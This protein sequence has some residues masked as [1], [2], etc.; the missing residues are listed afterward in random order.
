MWSSG[1]DGDMRE[2][3]AN[4]LLGAL[5]DF[6]KTSRGLDQ[7][8]SDYVDMYEKKL[9]WLQKC[10]GAVVS[11]NYSL[12]LIKNANI[13][14]K[15]MDEIFSKVDIW[16]NDE[17]VYEKTKAALLNLDNDVHNEKFIQQLP[18]EM[19]KL[20]F[21][22][23]SDGDLSS[24]ART[25][26]PMR[27]LCYETWSQVSLPLKDLKPKRKKESF[28]AFM[29]L[30]KMKS[31]TLRGLE[32]DEEHL[33]RVVISQQVMD[34]IVKNRES[35]TKLYLGG[36]IESASVMSN[37]PLLHKLTSLTINNQ[38]DG[39]IP[40]IEAIAELENLEELKITSVCQHALV[41][42]FNSLHKLRV[43]SLVHADDMSINAL[44]RNNPG[45]EE[46][47]LFW[48]VSAPAVLGLAEACPDLKHLHLTSCCCVKHHDVVE[49]SN[50]CSNLQAS[51]QSSNI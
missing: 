26:Y 32:R 42:I 19:W 12:F 48:R 45:L 49:I 4:D 38:D 9:E 14:K 37:L 21:A 39:S 7:S 16:K 5:D 2:P 18:R 30:T 28:D 13:I 31:I 36:S 44:A 23:L 17:D 40:G 50:H 25:C 24:L 27:M 29:G 51:K 10:G 15:D 34:S 41:T 6:V 22:F 33:S 3:G 11:K 1:G 8:M 43:V 46:V 47:S 35:L 20:V